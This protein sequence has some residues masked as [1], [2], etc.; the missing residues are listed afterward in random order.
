MLLNFTLTNKKEAIHFFFLMWYLNS[1]NL[2]SS[3]SFSLKI[4]LSQFN[5][6]LFKKVNFPGLEKDGEILSCNRNVKLMKI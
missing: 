3:I 6:E 5:D 1:S 2:F 4:E